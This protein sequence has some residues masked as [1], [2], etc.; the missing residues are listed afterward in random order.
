MFVDGVGQLSWHIKLPESKIKL[1]TSTIHVCPCDFYRT[2]MSMQT[3]DY[4]SLVAQL[5]EV[6]SS[7]HPC[8][9]DKCLSWLPTEGKRVSRLLCSR[10]EE[11][12][13]KAYPASQPGSKKAEEM[14]RTVLADQFVPGLKRK[15]REQK[16]ILSNSMTRHSSR[17]KAQRDSSKE[18]IWSSNSI[19]VS[20]R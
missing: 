4:T 5:T 19:S 17:S 9:P 10:S 6:Y 20:Y 14:G 13:L 12:F 16:E 1:L 15:W 8:N 3:A 18:Q 2:C 11:T 7:P